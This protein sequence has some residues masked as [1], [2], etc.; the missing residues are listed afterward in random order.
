[1]DKIVRIGDT[2]CFFDKNQNETIKYT[3]NDIC[4]YI[5]DGGSYEI[6]FFVN[7]Q[8]EPIPYWMF[9][10][11]N[12]LGLMFKSGQDAFYKELRAIRANQK[13]FK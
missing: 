7:E 4:V 8:E 11:M 1:M 5:T 12:E 10:E 2:I 13:V 3:V 9:K 6:G